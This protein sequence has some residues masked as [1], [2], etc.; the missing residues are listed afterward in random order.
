[1][2][3]IAVVA[4]IFLVAVQLAWVIK[5]DLAYLFA[6][7]IFL[8]VGW[9]FIFGLLGYLN[10]GMEALVL[11]ISLA[12]ILL[13]A[14]SGGFRS[15]LVSSSYAPSTVTFV[16]LSLI[17]LYKSK[18][19]MLSQ[20]D[21]FTH[22]GL[23]VKAMYEYSA[24]GPATPVDFM[25]TTYPPGIPLFQYFVLDFS[26]GW[27]EGL[28]FWATHLIVISIIVS[29]LAKSSYKY[30]SEIF[31]KLFIA[32]A[33]SSVFF[34]NF[35]NI[36]ADP[37]LA[38]AFGFLLFAAIQ[39]S[40]LDG[41]WAIVLALTAGFVTLI[42][43]AGIYFAATAILINIVATLFTIKFSLGKKA[44]LAFVPALVSL[45]TVGAV[46]VSWNRF[47]LDASSSVTDIVRA[48]VPLSLNAANDVEA[49][50]ANF[51]SAFF[52]INLRP[53]YSVPM[54]SIYW[55][56][57]CGVFFL[58]W[59][60]LSG[61]LN[62]KRNIA[63]GI[64]LL[65]TTAGYFGLILYSY[66]TVFGTGEAAGLASYSRYIG[67]WYQG[68]FFAIVILVLSEFSLGRYLESSA[69]SQAPVRSKSVH[70]QASLF[71]VAF[72]GVA[73]L[74]SVHNYLLM[75]NVSKYQGSEVR[76][77]F[78]PIKQAIEDANMPEQ[79]K[80]YIIANHTVG[81]EYYVLRYEMAGMKFGKV[82]W[83]IG[84][85]FG[86]GDIWTDPTWDIDKWSQELRAFDF[87]ALYS[88]TESFNNEFGSLFES[89][90]VDPNSVYR[91]IK[92]EDMVSLSKVS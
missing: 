33:A 90:I 54:A 46:W 5:I 30:L 32:L 85:T 37:T 42:K 16:S 8:I 62:Q 41:R 84:S 18:D 2:E 80:V 6:P 89:G 1:M 64:T 87:V 39:A 75:L 17:S 38:L 27:R 36:Y 31:L 82:P 4:V 78:I 11:F 69:A 88:T 14:K 51:V 49:I 72:I 40:R 22:W 74:S 63:I 81:F 26:A 73:M 50:S 59:A 19:W 44:G 66:L 52:N 43:P 60:M 92:T 65:V 79:S 76:A 68:V 53:S 3:L 35:D 10:L 13:L 91:I 77:S 86:D 71:L 56:I 25:V 28:L 70:R 34:N 48:G 23:V 24:L 55:T 9:E 67:T 12:L 83:S 58:T 21:E 47:W 15:H 29:V 20:W 61:K 57:L 45:T 7:A